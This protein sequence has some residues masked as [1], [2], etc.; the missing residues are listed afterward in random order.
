MIS[1][2]PKFKPIEIADREALEG[3]FRERPSQV[4]EFTFTNL[5]GWRKIHNY[6]I[7]KYKDGF[8]VLKESKGKLSFLQP[9]VTNNPAEA[10]QA[11]F[12]YLK[13]KTGLPAIERIDEDFIAA[14]A[15]DN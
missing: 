5:F 8:L 13:E 14:S 9:I 4:S 10:V 15:W 3:Y 11:C 1:I 12:E 7:S 6:Q 2:F